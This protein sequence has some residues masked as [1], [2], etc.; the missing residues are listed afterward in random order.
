MPAVCLPWSEIETVLLD[1]DGALLDLRF[2]NHFWQEWVPFHYAQRHGL[3][4]AEARAEV[5]KRTRAMVGTLEWYCLDYWSRELELDVVAL[6]HKI[7]DRIALHPHVLEFLQTVRVPGRRVALVTNA[8]RASLALKMEKTGL[9]AFFDTL[10]CAHDLGAAKEQAEFWPRLRAQLP[11]NPATTL[12]VDDTPS[13]LRTARAY[14]IAWLVAIA[15]PD[16]GQ[17]P[18]LSSEFPAIQDFSELQ[19]SDLPLN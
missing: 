9:A 19:P 15:Q 7:A 8:H 6:K 11:F 3:A 1:M 10:V 5:A 16:S 2:D 18:R 12:L 13:I 14:G 4:L 17:P